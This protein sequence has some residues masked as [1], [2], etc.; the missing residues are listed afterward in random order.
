MYHSLVGG[1]YCDIG[2]R[3]SAY[4]FPEWFYLGVGLRT[5]DRCAPGS[6]AYCVPSGMS[7]LVSCCAAPLSWSSGVL[8]TCVVVFVRF[9]WVPTS[10]CTCGV[11]VGEFSMVWFHCVGFAVLPP[12]RV[13]VCVVV[14]WLCPPVGSPRLV[15]GASPFPSSARVSS[16]C[17]AVEL[18]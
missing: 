9:W 7:S 18:V 12:C 5:C 2:G 11:R 13:G 1:R 8:A 14:V 4:Y 10:R 15:R 3:V 6:C 16:Y 17:L